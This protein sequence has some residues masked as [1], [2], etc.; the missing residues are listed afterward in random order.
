MMVRISSFFFQYD[1]GEL[2][3]QTKK[4]TTLISILKNMLVDGREEMVT[5]KLSS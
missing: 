4:S 3:L 5:T 2:L 1:K